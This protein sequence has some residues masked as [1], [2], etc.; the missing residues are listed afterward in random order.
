MA[1]TIFLRRVLFT[2]S[3][4]VSLFGSGC[5]GPA[6]T[7]KLSNYAA[8][9]GDDPAKWKGLEPGTRYVQYAPP[10]A[11][12][13]WIADSL[14]DLEQGRGKALSGAAEG[15]EMT[16]VE[17]VDAYV[18]TGGD[19]FA[20][21]EVRRG[22]GGKHW[23]KLPAGS[24]QGCLQPVPPGLE[25]A[26]KLV[27]KQL[28]FTPWAPTCDEVQAAGR[29]PAAMLVDAEGDVALA[30]EG[31]ALGPV[32]AQAMAAGKTGN[33]VWATLG[34]G[35]LKVRVDVLSKCFS[36]IGAEH[37]TRPGDPF[38]FLR[39]PVTRCEQD[40]DDDKPHVECRTTLGVWEGVMSD[41]A[42]ELRPVRRTLGP[43][44]FLEGKLVNGARYARTIVAVS[45]GSAPDSRRQRLYAELTPAMRT[46]MSRDATGIR[47]ADAGASDATYKIGV[48]LSEVTISDLSTTEVNETSKYKV[49]DD[50]RQ[51]PKKPAARE[52][53]SAARSALTQA[54][55]D[56]QTRKQ[57]FDREKKKLIDECNAQAAKATGWSAVAAATGCAAADGL[58]QP[59]NSEVTTART[60]LS[61]AESELAK[62]PDTITVPIMADWPYTKKQYS[63]TVTSVLSISLQAADAGAPKTF[64]TPLQ[65]TWTDFEVSDDAA[66]NVKGHAPDR[67]PIDNPDGLVPY[68]AAAAS[69]AI[70]TRFRAA[71]AEAQ[72]E[73]ARKAMAAAGVEASKPGFE[74][75]DALAFDTVGKR[76][77]KPLLRGSSTLVAGKL[78]SV[79]SDALSLSADQCVLAVAAG[80]AETPLALTLRTSDNSF[81]DTRESGFAI[82]EVCQT[83]LAKGKLPALELASKSA[84]SVKWTLFRVRAAGGGS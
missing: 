2:A 50:V 75:V 35:A 4:S 45:V 36:A 6:K 82:V 33:Q 67:G 57:D 84:G 39:L 25:E 12:A 11:C 16:V 62:E 41:T 73:A 78:L 40:T 71:M 44:H 65:Y 7:L 48:E 46:A 83:E 18:R 51:N 9:S 19:A 76:L 53:V 72:I 66:H 13:A 20:A 10:G 14:A 43:V 69:S 49:R 23:L 28:V 70:T 42:V 30:V 3:I 80:V 74:T 32:H 64:Q 55:A 68:I 63:R 54:E 59:S 58:L 34:N 22:D 61:T 37:A 26:K 1:T 5:A 47:M 15:K 21:I 31:L 77:E 79:P 38:G 24:S 52:R 60:E 27:G 56:F 29:A 81:A 8:T 17:I